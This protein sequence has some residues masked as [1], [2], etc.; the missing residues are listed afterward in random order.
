MTGQDEL[1]SFFHKADAVQGFGI[2]LDRSRV[3]AISLSLII[4]P[5]PPPPFFFG[6][7]VKVILY[8][9][10]SSPSLYL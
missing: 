3:V 8:S 5:P 1:F 7:G 9:P 2:V 6:R 4:L 10:N